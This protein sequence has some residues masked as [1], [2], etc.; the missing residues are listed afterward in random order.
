MLLLLLLKLVR[1]H[2]PRVHPEMSPG[3]RLSHGLLWT[4]TTGE[5]PPGWG[6]TPVGLL[7]NLDCKPWSPQDPKCH[8]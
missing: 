2:G 1:D 3:M 5:G 4:A 6:T 8:P 7:H